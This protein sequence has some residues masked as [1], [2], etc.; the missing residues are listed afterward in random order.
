[1]SLKDLML[2]GNGN[3]KVIAE[4]ENGV[5]YVFSCSQYPSFL[6]NCKVHQFEIYKGCL[7]VTLVD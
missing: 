4:T 6:A 3:T 7:C 2:L 1:M 5:E